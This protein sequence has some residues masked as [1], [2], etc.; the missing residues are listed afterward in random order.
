M[1]D[2]WQNLSFREKQAALL[3]SIV[4]ILFLFYEMVW[5]PFTD[6]IESLRH[7]LIQNQALLTWM[8]D[9]DKKIQ[10]LEKNQYHDKIQA[11]TSLLSLIQNQLQ[12]TPLGRSVSEVR[13]ADNNA[14]ELQFEKVNFDSLIVWLTRLWQQHGL[15]VTDIAVKPTGARGIVKGNVVLSR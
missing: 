13:Q 12:Q 3:G 8:Q 10:S 5:S 1:K 4:I 11:K 6:H 2:W 7:S 15:L 9:T 14:V